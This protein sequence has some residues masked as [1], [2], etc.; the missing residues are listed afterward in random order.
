MSNL[1]LVLYYR[2]LEWVQNSPEKRMDLDQ[3]KQLFDDVPD[4]DAKRAL[5]LKFIFKL[6]GYCFFPIFVFFSFHQTFLSNK[7]V[8][9]NKLVQANCSV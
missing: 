2:G 6:I 3:F 9:Q 4:S 5:D 8:H 1:F 7:P